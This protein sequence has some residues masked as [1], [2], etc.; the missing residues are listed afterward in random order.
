VK[1]SGE[2][3]A[4]TCDKTKLRQVV[5]SLLTSAAKFTGC[6]V[7]TMH[8]RRKTK[9]GSDWVETRVDDTGIGIAEHD[10]AKLF[11]D[12][13]QVSAATAGKYGG[14]GLGPAV[15]QK[16][17]ALLGGA[18]RVTSDVGRGSSFVV[19]LPAELTIEE[20]AVAA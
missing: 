16:L 19:R 6:G 20:P 17:C 14:A 7:V 4:V 5:L 11:Q 9:A 2:L 3:G 18:I 15:S 8:A 1:A 13:A 10:L 12:F